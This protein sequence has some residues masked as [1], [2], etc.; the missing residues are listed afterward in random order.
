MVERMDRERF[1]GC[2]NYGECTMACPKSIA[3]EN[4]AWMNKEFLRA[5]LV[6]RTGRAGESPTL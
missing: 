1:G 6:E 2:T 5:T 4:I 3:Q